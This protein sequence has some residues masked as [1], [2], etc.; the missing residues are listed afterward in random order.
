MSGDRDKTPARK[1]SQASKKPARGTGAESARPE[2]R[3][4]LAGQRGGGNAAVTRSLKGKK[5]SSTATAA[6]KA[7]AAPR[8]AKAGAAPPSPEGAHPVSEQLAGGIT[9]IVLDGDGDQ[10]KELSLRFRVLETWP[11][12]EGALHTDAPK[13]LS[14][15]ATQLS[16]G[17]SKT[18]AFTL[19]ET[20]VGAGRL[21]PHL[22]ES[23]T[24][25]RAP[26]RVS[27]FR[28]PRAA[29]LEILPGTHTKSQ[30]RY[31]LRVGGESVDLAFPRE[32]RPMRRVGS[33]APAVDDHGIHRMDVTL[34]RHK[35]VFRLTF[36]STGRDTA[37]L[38]V[39]SLT[40]KEAPATRGVALSLLTGPLQPK[41]VPSGPTAVAIDLTGD[42]K[43]DVFLYDRLTTAPRGF[44]GA[45]PAKTKRIHEITVTG[46]AVAKDEAL[47]FELRRGAFR[48]DGGEHSEPTKDA[49]RT[50]EAPGLMA[51]QPTG[52]G[53]R[54]EIAAVDASAIVRYRAHAATGLIPAALVDAAET[55]VITLNVTSPPP[56][57]TALT[58]VNA[59]A[60]A[61]WDARK[62]LGRAAPKYGE[63]MWYVPSNKP[64]EHDLRRAVA[65]GK[66]DDARRCV[67]AV[68]A[69][70]DAL[71]R[72]SL[73]HLG[74]T[75]TAGQTA[76]E[77]APSQETHRRRRDELVEMPKNARRIAVA[78]HPKE[79]DRN[80]PG[81][82]ESYARD[83]Y[84]WEDMEK[85]Y[86]KDLTS[87]AN[88]LQVAVPKG[89]EREPP[90]SLF[91]ELDDADYFPAG[92]LTVRVSG[93]KTR[94]IALVNNGV[95]LK[96]W[97]SR[98]S[99]IALVAG[100][101]ATMIGGSLL[102]PGIVLIDMASF[103][104]AWRAVED[105]RTRVRHGNLDAQA[106]TINAIS[107]ASALPHASAGAG[108]LIV[109]LG[110]QAAAKGTPMTG[111]LARL[112]DMS[113]RTLIPISKNIEM[114][115]DGAAF[116]ALT[117]LGLERWK[118]IEEAPGGGDNT[119]AK[120]ELLLILVG[121]GA[122]LVFGYKGF[123]D[124][125]TKPH[126]E[127]LH[128]MPGPNGTVAFTFGS[129]PDVPG[130][131][132]GGPPTGPPPGVPLPEPKGPGPSPGSA[133][134]GPGASGT[135]PSK[136]PSSTTYSFTPGPP[137]GSVPAGNKDGDTGLGGKDAGA[138]PPSPSSGTPRKPPTS[139][140]KARDED[141]AT[142]EFVGTLARYWP[143]QYR[144][145]SREKHE[146]LQWEK[147]K[148]HADAKLVTSG[149]SKLVELRNHLTL[150]IRSAREGPGPR[151][152]N[153]DGEQHL[154]MTIES[155]LRGTARRPSG[156]S[157]TAGVPGRSTSE[158]AGA[159]ARNAGGDPKHNDGSNGG[160]LPDSRALPAHLTPTFE[161]ARALLL[162]QLRDPSANL[163]LVQSG[164]NK[165]IAA[166]ELVAAELAMERALQQ[167]VGRLSERQTR[168]EILEST[169]EHLNGRLARSE[170][171]LPAGANTPRANRPNEGTAPPSQAIPRPPST[172]PKPNEL[173]FRA[174][175]Q[176]R[177]FATFL[178]GHRLTKQEK[179]ALR[180][181]AAQDPTTDI[182]L[183]T[184]ARAKLK[185]ARKVILGDLKKARNGRSE[186]DPDGTLLPCIE[187]ILN[188]TLRMPPRGSGAR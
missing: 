95:S 125:K 163:K 71:V 28:N 43:A 40:D 36:R 106:F 169:L 157:S 44:D 97:L 172:T 64:A 153:T 140:P 182:E 167:S 46:P 15:T 185:A 45:G 87:P 31:A 49:I 82:Q 59:Y 126:R 147:G 100:V 21:E 62:S 90:D 119:A 161:E 124:L 138:V 27:L 132:L 53:L 142:E 171:A 188:S 144:L 70:L 11:E 123:T 109:H 116:I 133:P 54:A 88:P 128:L 81:Y 152:A 65:D 72:N 103:A 29:M 41:V 23:V 75:T 26:T 178:P 17:R 117:P 101:A 57:A 19:P 6:A 156:G 52:Q 83:M 56:V 181:G 51:P 121:V 9:R 143:A 80:V 92:A 165:L 22:R 155:L 114:G 60:A 134:N 115:I 99:T 168:R 111:Q 179:T 166:R 32:R 94:R 146:L 5:P 58:R 85:W 120:A 104:G 67:T 108:R 102:V 177:A 50:Q 159:P 4:V 84:L 37:T 74:R 130:G 151:P 77:I 162:F 148:P 118:E 96:T 48:D 122:A 160:G 131:S 76:K 139:P 183:F 33:A 38:G 149:R 14:V 2:I 25:G 18:A 176:S 112:A 105:T 127:D 91:S 187:A 12:K 66:W 69:E 107:L 170:R 173:D 129:K 42:G 1:T 8:S 135:F 136:N 39:Q 137:K 63:M 34:G 86:L 79:T 16:S 154:L 47:R 35:D 78:Y 7:G 73:H 110:G 89:T 158:P 61:Y 186:R 184:G 68:I 141:M 145:T 55:L 3:R 180:K 30:S 175:D 164:R 93:G 13:R 24:D 98:I 20:V 174:L 113:N 150:R 10:H